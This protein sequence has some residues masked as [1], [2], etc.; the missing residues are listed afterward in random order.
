MDGSSHVV[1]NMAS[2]V[3]G[4]LKA[5]GHDGIIGGNDDLWPICANW[6][7]VR[8]RSGNGQRGR[9]TRLSPSG[10]QLLPSS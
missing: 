1:G 10:H 2:V 9:E 4:P 5:P 8:N 3:R 7:V 6:R